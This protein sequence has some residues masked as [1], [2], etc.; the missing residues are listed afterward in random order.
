MIDL[1]PSVSAD[2]WALVVQSVTMQLPVR[3]P[4]LQWLHD[5]N[6]APECAQSRTHWYQNEQ[7]KSVL[8]TM[9]MAQAAT[10]LIRSTICSQI[11]NTIFQPK[12]VWFVNIRWAWKVFPL[13]GIKEEMPNQNIQWFCYDHHYWIPLLKNASTDL[14]TH[15]TLTNGARADENQKEPIPW[16]NNETVVRISDPSIKTKAAVLIENVYQC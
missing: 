10:F 7:V 13:F 4:V 2:L 11:F 3:P 8:H 9:C 14:C 6:S 5:Y 16:T 1:T 15:S 12:C